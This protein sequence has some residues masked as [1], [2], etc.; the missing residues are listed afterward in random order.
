MR[1]LVT[2][3]SI[4]VSLSLGVS[5]LCAC[6]GV[7]PS[8]RAEDARLQVTRVVLFQNGLAYVER[9]GTTARSTVDLATRAE[10]L[11][12]VLKSLTVVDHGGGGIGS[13]RVLPFDDGDATVRLRVGLV[14]DGPHDLTVSYV[15][16]ASGWRPTYRLIELPEGRVRVQGLAVVDN[17][18]GEP[19]DGVSVA[20]STELPLSFRFDLADERRTP[21]PRFDSSGRLLP[22]EAPLAIAPDES[23]VQLAYG[24]E[25]AMAPEG[26]ARAGRRVGPN[27][28]PP[29]PAAPIDPLQAIDDSDAE[30]GFTLESPERLSLGDGESG[31]IPFVDQIVDGEE[32]LLFKPSPAR[33]P[34]RHRPYRA[35]LFRN[36][37]EAPLLMGPVA[38]YTGGAFAGD[39]V[40]GLIPGGAH[41]FVAFASDPSVHVEEDHG[42]TE[43][44]IHAL[45]VT[46][47]QLEVELQ[48]VH[49]RRYRVT[50]P[51]PWGDRVFLF[52]DKLDGFDPRELPDGTVV[53]P[54]GYYVPTAAPATE[55]SVAFDLVRERRTTV[56]IAAEPAHAYVPALLTLLERSGRLEVDRLREIVDRIDELSHERRRWQEDLE[57]HRQ[58]LA[59][60][61]DALEALRD[62]PA[63]AALRRQL[64]GRVA[65][66]VQEVDELTRRMVA[67]NT[68]AVSLRQ[69]WYARLRELVLTG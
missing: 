65:Q 11:D 21:R 48:A 8:V 57:V 69:E 22:F 47:G 31:L 3:S 14:G 51:Q 19:W 53:T 20:L 59:E 54:G 55:A 41:A 27:D 60:R 38:V 15:T 6:G 2:V 35:M 9:R 62:V 68:E 32:V 61:R 18:S 37:L 52:A 26:S 39:G 13:V 45:R 16:E 29:A 25:N 34:S 33:G 36:P 46:A 17:H 28:D 24:L 58:A 64:G 66:G 44:E 4:V 49:R 5:T 7:G 40:T 43:D 56:N 67:A 1:H 23:Q 30:G 42:Q 63:N 50:S 12:D 10:H